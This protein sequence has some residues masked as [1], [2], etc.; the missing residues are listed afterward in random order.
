MF[1][2]TDRLFGNQRPILSGRRS[3]DMHG[4]AFPS[5]VSGLSR[6]E[7]FSA[8]EA[9]ARR[10]R[11]PAFVDTLNQRVDLISNIQNAM[12]NIHP[13]VADAI[14]D[15]FDGKATASEVQYLLSRYGDEFKD[16]SESVQSL[17]YAASCLIQAVADLDSAQLVYAAQNFQ[18]FQEAN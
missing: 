2:H 13:H 9:H 14:K 17:A 6:S 5:G 8:Q 12:Q 15:F 16:E 1:Q 7:V 11:R 4:G 10:E 3:G 18:N